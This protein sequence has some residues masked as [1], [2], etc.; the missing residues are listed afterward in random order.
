MAFK[1]GLLESIRALPDVGSAAEAEIVPL[2]GSATDN[3]VWMEGRARADKMDSNFSWIGPDYLRTMGMTLLAG[4]DFDDRDNSGSPKVAIVNQAFARHMGLGSAVVG[5]R[6]RREATASE[7]ETV[8]E[9]VGLVKDTKYLSLRE[10]FTPIAF[11]SAAQDAS[12]DPFAQF[13][14]HS[15]A[16]L[17]NLTSTIRAPRG[18]PA[19]RSRFS[20]FETTV[21]EGLL[22]ERLMATLSGFFGFWRR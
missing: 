13:V 8:F 18:Q 22:P 19:N 3:N 16:P 15:S 12:P 9:I 21:R 6:F 14:I 17:A 11:L 20:S 1:R 10:E 4:R 7:P 2:S 5:Q